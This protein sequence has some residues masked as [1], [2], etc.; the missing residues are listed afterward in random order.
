[1]YTIRCIEKF[2]ASS[3]SF[4][5]YPFERSNF[6]FRFELA[7]IK[8]KIARQDVKIFFDYYPTVTDD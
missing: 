7:G 1:L 2:Y 6:N 5:K 4:S 8:G 3:D